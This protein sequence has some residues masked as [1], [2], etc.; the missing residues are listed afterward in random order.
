MRAKGIVRCPNPVSRLAT[1]TLSSRWLSVS[2]IFAGHRG[3]GDSGCH[4][5]P[6]RG[7]LAQPWAAPR[8]GKGRVGS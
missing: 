4:E 3:V 1:L 6:R 2:R 5:E 8:V 7:G